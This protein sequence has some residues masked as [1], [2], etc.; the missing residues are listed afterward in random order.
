MCI[1]INIDVYNCI[2]T[3]P[4]LRAPALRPS[5]GTGRRPA[6]RAAPTRPHRR[7]DAESLDRTCKLT[8]AGLREKT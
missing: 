4:A 6:V 8:R 7:G 5:R 3:R 1:Y 2:H